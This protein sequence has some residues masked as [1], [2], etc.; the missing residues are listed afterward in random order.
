MQTLLTTSLEK[1]PSIAVT[2]N[3]CEIVDFAMLYIQTEFIK[4][5]QVLVATGSDPLQTRKPRLLEQVHDTIRRLHYSWRTEQAYVHWIKRFIYWSGKRH[6]STLG[7][8][9]VTALS[10]R[11]RLQGSA[12]RRETP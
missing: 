9:E 6:P 2:R 3:T 8:R 10:G 4:G 12:C 7:E 1:C 5:V 11:N